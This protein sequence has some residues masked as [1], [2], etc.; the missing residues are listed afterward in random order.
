MQTEERLM[1]LGDPAFREFNVK[2][3]PSVDPKTVIGV[4][5]PLIRQLARELIKSGEWKTFVCDL[6][7]KWFEENQ[8]HA[9]ILSELRDEMVVRAEL[10][11]FLPFIDNW[12]T[13]DQ[14]IPKVFAKQP[15]MLLGDIK[16]WMASEHMYTVRFAI[17]L[18]MRH[19]LDERFDTVYADMVAA[20]R[21]EAYYVN[22][23]AAWYFATALAKQYDAVLPYLEESRLPVWVHNKTIRKATESYR[24]TEAHKRYLKGL[25]R[26]S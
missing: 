3:I 22:M 7:H 2:L 24:V 17:G 9:L 23:M 16:R 5:T 14:L 10:E 8:V 12:A 20:V 11:R 6:P 15:E 25:V 19:F 1:A 18:L 21:S 26:A 13:C 4:K